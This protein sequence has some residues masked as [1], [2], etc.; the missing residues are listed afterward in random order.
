MFSQICKC[1][2][3]SNEMDKSVKVQDLRSFALLMLLKNLDKEIPDKCFEEENI[4][5]K[6]RKEIMEMGSFDLK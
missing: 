1:T 3:V 4:V 2:E 5:I 6:K